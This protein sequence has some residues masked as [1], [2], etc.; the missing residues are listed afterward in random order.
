MR[1]DFDRI[2][3]PGARTARRGIGLAVATALAIPP[4]TGF[5]DPGAKAAGVSGTV[6]GR[7]FSADRTRLEGDR[8]VFRQGADFFAD[9]EVEVV[10]HFDPDEGLPEGRRWEASCRSGWSF[11]RPGPDVDVL[12]SW[13]EER[14]ALP[15]HRSACDFRL[16]L[17]FDDATPDGHLPG[18]ISL[19]APTLSSEISGRFSAE[20]WGFETEGAPLDLSRDE[21]EVLHHLARAWLGERA[22]DPVEIERHALGWVDRERGDA[23]PLAGFGLYWWRTADA[24]SPL[25]TKLQFEKRG[26]AWTVARALEPWQVALAHPR[27]PR[28]DLGAALSYRTASHFEQEHVAERGRSAVYVVRVQTL[29]DPRKGIAEASIRYVLDAD[30]VERLGVFEGRVPWRFGGPIARFLGFDGEVEPAE[31]RYLLR[32]PTAASDRARADA[33][34]IERRLRSDE[35]LDLVGCPSFVW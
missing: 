6:M 28:R 8:L 5:A 3:G 25:P 32:A 17:R 13:R 20:T 21:L 33:W 27:S 24:A 26:G 19:S 23:Q 12:L 22:G 10:L 29:Y 31:V 14:D 9:L 34:Q 18:E 4:V 2:L 16:E 11:G 30:D 7:D 35:E 1:F 15:S